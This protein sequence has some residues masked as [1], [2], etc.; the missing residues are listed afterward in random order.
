MVGPGTGLA[1]FRGFLQE[2]AWLKSQGTPVGRSMLFFGCR[3]HEQDFLYADELAALAHDGVT[4]LRVAFSRLP[5]EKKVYVQDLLL[6]ERDAVWQMIESG[7]VV[8]VCGDASR[9]APDVR[10]AFAAIH[11]QKTGGGEAAANRWL[12]ELTAENRYLVDVWAAS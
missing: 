8:Y 6:E 2:R 7:A 3:H 9:M 4:D 10:R 12:D 11:A 5:G 1:P